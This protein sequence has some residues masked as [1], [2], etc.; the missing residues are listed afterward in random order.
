MRILRF[1]GVATVGIL[2]AL[3]LT[4]YLLVA[5]QRIDEL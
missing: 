2:V 1:A 4:A 5:A 3:G